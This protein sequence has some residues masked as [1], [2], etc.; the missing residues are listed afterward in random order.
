MKLYRF[1]RLDQQGRPLG[2]PEDIHCDSDLQARFRGKQILAAEETVPVLDIWNGEGRVVQL[3]QA[4]SD[5]PATDQGGGRLPALGD[6]ID[7][8]LKF[9]RSML[10][11]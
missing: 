2:R 9:G 5:R 7:E 6:E 11:T 3:T 8:S 1:Y 4:D 10:Q